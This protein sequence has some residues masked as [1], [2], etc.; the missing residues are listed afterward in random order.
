MY[1]FSDNNELR[2]LKK[3]MF[4]CT[5]TPVKIFFKLSSANVEENNCLRLAYEP[6]G[7]S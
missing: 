7:Y 3:I 4:H 2:D 1:Y 5:L 6:P